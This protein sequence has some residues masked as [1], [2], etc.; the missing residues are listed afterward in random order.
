MLS[1]F[2]AMNLTILCKGIETI[3]KIRAGKIEKKALLDELLG[4]TKENL[5]TI[6]DD[7]LRHDLPIHNV[8]SELKTTC[9]EKAMRAHKRKKIDFNLLKQGK[10]SYTSCKSQH[11]YSLYKD[12]D[13]ERLYS[14]ILEK[15]TSF[16]KKKRLHYKSQRG[17]SKSVSPKRR[18]NTVVDLYLMLSN[19]LSSN[20]MYKK[21]GS[22]RCTK[23]L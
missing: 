13:T 3:N 19:H 4:E 1:L 12:Y 8:L 9:L 7:Y 23:G 15:I 22:F 16:K 5:E 17:W 18:M 10:I 6:R 2:T 20:D 14:N 11:Q 21:L